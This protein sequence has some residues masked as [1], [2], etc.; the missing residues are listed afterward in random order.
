LLNKGLT[1]A[2][3]L[4][5][6]GLAFAP[7]ITGDIEKTSDDRDTLGMLSENTKEN[8]NCMIFGIVTNTRMQSDDKPIMKLVNFLNNLDNFKF[9]L[10]SI[11]GG[12]LSRR[13][14]VKGDY[15]PFS[16]DATIAFSYKISV[17]D[18]YHN[19]EETYY[20]S[21]GWLWTNGDN[22]IVEWNW[23]F[24]GGYE[25][26]S[27][28]TSAHSGGQYYVGAKGFTGIWFPTPIG[29]FFYGTASHVKVEEK[30]VLE[31]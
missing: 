13:L 25:G 18:D 15:A 10:L 29:R 28:L 12:I 6:I 3:I 30:T 19:I 14:L 23:E 24:M 27:T 9:P 11:L 8:F 17:W 4:L 26:Y 1:V 7:G 5:F 21:K 31:Y 22:G 2:V 16:R 20:Y